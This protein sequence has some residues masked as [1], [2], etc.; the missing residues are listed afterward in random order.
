MT[1]KHQREGELQPAQ[2]LARRQRRRPESSSTLARRTQPCQ[3][4]SQRKVSSWLA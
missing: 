3:A 2:A 1:L 4:R